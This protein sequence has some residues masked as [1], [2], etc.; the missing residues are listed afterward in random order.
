MRYVVDANI[1]LSGLIANSTT[2]TLLVEIEPELLTPAYVHEEIGKYTGLVVEKSGLEVDDVEELI[3]TLFK[4]IDIVPRAEILGSLQKAAR[5][6]RDVDPDDALYLA[7]AI[8]RDAVIWSDDGDYEHQ[9]IVDVATTSEI[10][11]R[12]G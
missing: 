4:R 7:V 5:A 12:Y 1:I 11:E 3:Q 2:R 9:D 8:E 6:M 10:F